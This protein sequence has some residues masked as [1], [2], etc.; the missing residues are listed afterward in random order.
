[1]RSRLSQ[2]GAK[3][4]GAS[5][6]TRISL[7]A[8]SALCLALWAISALMPAKAIAFIPDSER[9]LR[10][11][12][13]V[14]RSSGR[15][16]ALQLDLT[17]RID[18]QD[19]IA[20]GQ[21]ITHPTGL[22]RLELR[23]FGG[24]IDRYVLSGAELMGAKDGR[25]LEQP[26]PLLQPL[27][28]MQPSSETTLRAALSTFGVQTGLVGLATCGDEDCFVFGDPRLAD[29]ETLSES[30]FLGNALGN[31]LSFGGDASGRDGN[32]ISDFG[33]FAR[34]W[35]D[36]QELQVRRIDRDN[37]V[38]TLFGPM[39][40]F[41]KIKVPAWLEIHE[42][43]AP[44]I[45]FEIERAVEVNAPP[46]A[47]SQQWLMGLPADYQGSNPAPSPARSDSP[48]TSPRDQY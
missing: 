27:F 24:R 21:L 14:N 43:G 4:V 46:T 6:P 48:R 17:M 37:G 20:A 11:I 40:N 13:R 3:T 5:F 33:G 42:P 44:P 45:R 32:T 7:A 29:S 19:P 30:S 23:G 2:A 8:V 39:V 36:T 10:E 18:D 47:F 28:L 31:A 16:K 41:A 25:R 35:V 34:F 9:A 38:F 26:Q 12:T 15:T 22:A 1:M